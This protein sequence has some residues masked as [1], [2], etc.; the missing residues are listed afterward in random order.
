MIEKFQI[1]TTNWTE[2]GY[3]LGREVPQTSK[4]FN[5]D[6][7]TA[8]GFILDKNYDVLDRTGWI[9]VMDHNGIPLSGRLWFRNGVRVTP[10]EVF[11]VLTNEEKFE[12]LW[13]LDQWK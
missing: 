1:D 9:V 3:F 10:M 12:A 4:K 7:R 11:D 2:L 13:E 8:W 5:P 6:Y